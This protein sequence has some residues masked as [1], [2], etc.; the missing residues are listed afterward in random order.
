MLQPSRRPRLLPPGPPAHNP[1]LQA[2]PHPQPGSAPRH[3]HSTL[4][5]ATEHL[6][7][8]LAECTPGLLLPPRGGGARRQRPPR[9]SRAL[10]TSIRTT[11]KLGLP[12]K[13]RQ[14]GIAHA[15]CEEGPPGSPPPPGGHTHGGAQTPLGLLRLC[16]GPVPRPEPAGRGSPGL[17]RRP[18]LPG[19]WVG[20]RAHPPGAPEPPRGAGF[21]S[22]RGANNR[23]ARAAPGGGP[24]A[25]PRLAPVAAKQEAT[26]WGAGPPQAP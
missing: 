18:F 13:S 17:S 25:S 22:S 23:C 10:I 2:P 8:T 3:P 20:A 5:P 6:L 26:V 11:G 9:P 7:T 19:Q 21:C 1:L 15:G 12:E 24:H 16:S 14:R 4:G